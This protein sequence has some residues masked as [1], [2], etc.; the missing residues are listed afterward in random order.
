MKNRDGIKILVFV[1][2]KKN[3]LDLTAKLAKSEEDNLNKK[4]R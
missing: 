3:R 2:K 4:E 1:K